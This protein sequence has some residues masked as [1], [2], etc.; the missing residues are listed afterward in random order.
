MN[1]F[2]NTEY[3]NFSQLAYC[4]SNVLFSCFVLICLTVKCK[5]YA[6]VLLQVAIFY[7]D[8]RPL[9]GKGVGRKILDLVH[10]TYKAELDGKDFAYDGKKSLFTVGALPRNKLEFTIII[11]D[12]SSSGF[13]LLKSVWRPLQR[14]RN[15]YPSKTYK[16]EISYAAKIPVQ[17]IAKTLNGQNLEKSRKALRVLDIILRQHLAKKYVLVPFLS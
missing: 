2:I 14:L 7:G 1:I 11:Q 9:D 8:G 12:I 3:V 16:V 13:S 6:Y 15:S 5:R 4:A 10:D 17:A